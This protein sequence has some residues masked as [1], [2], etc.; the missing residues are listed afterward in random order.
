[1]C[2]FVFLQLASTFISVTEPK[3]VPKTKNAPKTMKVCLS[4]TLYLHG[5]TFV[6]TFVVISMFHSFLLVFFKCVFFF[7]SLSTFLFLLIF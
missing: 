6:V 2:V 3:S 5:V 1:M 7:V 4:A